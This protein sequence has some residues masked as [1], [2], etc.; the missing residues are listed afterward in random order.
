M[1]HMATIGIS[2]A[3]FDFSGSG[4]S[5]GEYITLGLKERFD[6]KFVIKYLRKE[7]G[8]KEYFI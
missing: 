7:F 4:M 5:E 3:S 8:F 1:E 6:V 2:F